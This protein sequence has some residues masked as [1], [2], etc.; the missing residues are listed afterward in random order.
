MVLLA[1]SGDVLRVNAEASR[2]FE[3]SAP[4]VLRAGRVRGVHSEDDQRLQELV[5]RATAPTTPEAGA[6]RLTG[7]D[8]LAIVDVSP[9]VGPNRLQGDDPAA[10]MLLHR[11]RRPTAGM[12]A[13]WQAIFGFTPTEAAVA[14]LLR[15]G[16]LDAEI[17]QAFGVRLSTVRTHVRMILAKTETRSKAELAHLLTRI[18]P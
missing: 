11:P 3:G 12:A 9:A 17:A 10:I 16:Q 14:E 8:D 18:A 4:L 15:Q 6:M 2:W 7:S 13:R 5:A 1:F